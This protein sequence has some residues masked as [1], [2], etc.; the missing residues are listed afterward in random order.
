MKSKSKNFNFFLKVENKQETKFKELSSPELKNLD[1]KKTSKNYIRG[2]SQSL[3]YFLKQ[4]SSLIDQRYLGA[5][6]QKNTSTMHT[7]EAIIKNLQEKI[8]NP[9]KNLKKDQI[10]NHA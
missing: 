5:S 1:S 2:H 3:Y 7:L 10:F 8:K 6:K 4:E 9:K